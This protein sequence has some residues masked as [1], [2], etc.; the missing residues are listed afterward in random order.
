VS[1]WLV[2]YSV[3]PAG[4]IGSRLWPLSRAS[5]PK[6]LHDLTGSGQTLLQ[7]TVERLSPIAGA[8]RLLIVT[9]AAHESAVLEQVPDISAMNL[10]LEPSPKDSTAAIALAA[11]ILYSRDPEAIIGSFAADHVINDTESFLEVVREAVTVAATGKIVTI[12]IEPTEP[13]VGFGYIKTGERIENSPN[14]REVEKFVE[15][16]DLK[17][18]QKYVSFTQVPLERR[19][20]YRPS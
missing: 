12:G 3:I 17:R 6:F 2:F 4:G 5:A 15:K 10:I 14:A 1:Q 8:D 7:D 20:V 18:A 16:P 9:G 13:S 19:Y 11:A